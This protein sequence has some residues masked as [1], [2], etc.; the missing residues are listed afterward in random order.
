[1]GVAIS[2]N[3]L[4]KTAAE[5]WDNAGAAS[6]QAIVS[7]D[8]Y[9][10]FTASETSSYRM[11]GLSQGDANQSYTDIDF[12]MYPTAN[13]HVYV[14]E[15]GVYRGD[16]GTYATGDLLRVAV[17]GGVVKYKKNGTVFYTSS[18]AP[19][20]PLL[21]DTSLYTA[22]STISNVVIS[23]NLSGG[24]GGSSANINW[25]VADQLGT[26][27]LVFDKTGSL[28]GTK[29]HDYLPFG[30]DIFAGTGSRTTGQGYQTSPNPND[31]LIN[32]GSEA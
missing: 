16:F 10:E 8:G 6:T 31:E 14:Y 22:G 4:T 23:G 12:A 21:V 15:G 2:G 13:S 30:E 17:E 24:G 19:S 18:V 32:G 3:S 9:V 27:R 28:A 11:C 7:G 29:R 25:L 5:G 26:P 1:L 20:Y